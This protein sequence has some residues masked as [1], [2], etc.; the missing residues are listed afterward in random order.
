MKVAI[1]QPYLLP[2]IGYFQLIN[3]VDV[4]VVYDNIKYT[5]K[6]WINRNRYLSNGIDAIFSLPIKKDSDFLDIVER[7]VSPDFNPSKM[8]NQLKEAYR[9]APFATQTMGL[10][11]TILMNDE[12]NL[13]RFIRHGLEKTC[14]HLGISTPILDSSSLAIDHALQSQDKVLA[15]CQ[16]TRANTYLNPIGGTALYSNDAFMK[17]GLELKFLRSTLRPYQQFG[18]AF[19]PWLSILDVMMFNAPEDLSKMI[20]SDFEIIT[21]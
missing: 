16:A 2:Y 12:R 13:F 11:E 10:L 21:A 14:Q 8:L 6:G 7:E 17:H 3:A 19:V 9:K 15:L 18:A 4:F 1:M 20:Q 5:K